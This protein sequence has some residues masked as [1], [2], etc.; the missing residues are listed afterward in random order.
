MILIIEI[1]ELFGLLVTPILIKM[2][3]SHDDR[4]SLLT[5]NSVNEAEL[6][7]QIEQEM[8]A[9]IMREQQCKMHKRRRIPVQ[10]RNLLKTSRKMLA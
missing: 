7:M 4:I 8:W 5:K 9:K 3:Q 6:R 2:R 1:L 10:N